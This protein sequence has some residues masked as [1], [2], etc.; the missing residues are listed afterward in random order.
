MARIPNIDCGKLPPRVAFPTL[1]TLPLMPAM[2]D[3]DRWLHAYDGHTCVHK[4][5]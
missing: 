2:V 1:P 5:Q 3:A 4:V